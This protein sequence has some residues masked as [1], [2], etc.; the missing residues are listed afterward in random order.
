MMPY[1]HYG[2]GG[3][4]IGGL[5]ILIFM[6]LLLAG[7][8]I[9]LVVLIRRPGISQSGQDDGALRILNERFARGEIDE[10]EYEQRRAI[11]KR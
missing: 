9:V 6:A 2:W 8:V 5:V 3:S 4:W 7:L 11:L 1:W 10:K